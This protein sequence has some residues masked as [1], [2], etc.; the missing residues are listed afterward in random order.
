MIPPG[1]LEL[2]FNAIDH[3]LKPSEQVRAC[4]GGFAVRLRRACPRLHG[5]R[6]LW[7]SLR[8]TN[9]RPNRQ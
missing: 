3:A 9:D 2:G 8:L 6:R 7:G 5:S 1:N 4:V